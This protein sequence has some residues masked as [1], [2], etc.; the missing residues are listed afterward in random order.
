MVQIIKILQSQ[1]QLTDVNLSGAA[2]GL[3][4][5]DELHRL[6]GLH[7]AELPKADLFRRIIMTGKCQSRNFELIINSFILEPLIF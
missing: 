6:S 7:H 3:S 2:G 1:S 5:P 4:Q